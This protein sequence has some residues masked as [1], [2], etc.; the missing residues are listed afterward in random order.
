MKLNNR[1]VVF[2][3]CDECIIRYI[4]IINQSNDDLHLELFEKKYHRTNVS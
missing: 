3:N 4:V 2:V 1:F